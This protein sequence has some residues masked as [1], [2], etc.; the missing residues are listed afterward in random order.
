LISEALS[1]K[2]RIIGFWSQPDQIY[3]ARLAA[4]QKAQHLIQFETFFVTP[5]HRANEF[6]D[7]LIERSH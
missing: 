6:A 3:A 7:A 1:T 5:G 2:A 4:I